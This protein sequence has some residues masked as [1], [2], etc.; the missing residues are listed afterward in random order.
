MAPRRG[1]CVGDFWPP[2]GG[3]GFRV[4]RVRERFWSISLTGTMLQLLENEEW[5]RGI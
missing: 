5:V 2:L 1:F 4:Q 3:L